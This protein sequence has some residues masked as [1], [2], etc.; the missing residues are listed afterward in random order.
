[1]TNFQGILLI[2]LLSGGSRSSLNLASEAD[3]LYESSFSG[4]IGN[5]GKHKSYSFMLGTFQSLINQSKPLCRGWI[6]WKNIS[7][8]KLEWEQQGFLNNPSINL[9]N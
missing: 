5:Y 1:M 8:L 9:S 7:L 4:R 6:R 2:H 3:S